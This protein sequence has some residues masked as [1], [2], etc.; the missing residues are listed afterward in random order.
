MNI[1]YL[2]NCPVLSAH[3]MAD[4]HTGSKNKGGKM[5]VEACQLLATCYP[6]DRLA[7]LDCPRTKKGTP[8][9]YGYYNHP[10]AVWVRSSGDHAD[11]LIRHG[12]AMCEEKIFRGG[13]QHFGLDFLKWCDKIRPEQ[14]TGWQTPYLAMPEELREDNAVDAY[15]AYYYI[16]KKCGIYGDPIEM[17]WTKREKP[18]WWPE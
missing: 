7:A 3:M 11:W 9:Q 6:L 15:R 1:F 12:I 10:C 14:T 2:D 13:K 16:T 18:D 8:R 5:I 4:I 17:N